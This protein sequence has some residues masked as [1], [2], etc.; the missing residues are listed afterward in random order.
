MPALRWKYKGGDYTLVRAQRGNERRGTA[1]SQ[2][3][4]NEF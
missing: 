4:R 3:F 1:N 2:Q